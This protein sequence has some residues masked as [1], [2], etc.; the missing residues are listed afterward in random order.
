M[1]EIS[2]GQ[3]ECLFLLNEIEEGEFGDWFQSRG[4]G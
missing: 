4:T 1:E 2:C 3:N